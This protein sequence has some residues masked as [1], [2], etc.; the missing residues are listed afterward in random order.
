MKKYFPGFYSSDQEDLLA[1][2][3]NASIVIDTY[4]LLDLF[5][6][7]DSD[8]FLELLQKESIKKQLW[9]SYDAAWLYH[10]LMHNT[11]M[12]EINNVK[13]AMAHITNLSQGITNQYQ[14]PHIED[15]LFR[16]IKPVVQKL[17]TA[18]NENLANLTGKLQSKT[19]NIVSSINNLYPT[20]NLGKEFNEA[21]LKRIY[22]N[23]FE[24]YQQEIPPGYLND[25]TLKNERIKYHDLIIWN[26]IQKYAKDEKKNI[27]FVTNRIRPDWFFIYDNKVI[28]PRKE[29]INEFKKNT[30]QDICIITAHHFVDKN[31]RTGGQHG[32][33]KKLLEQLHDTPVNEYTSQ[34]TEKSAE[35]IGKETE[36]TIG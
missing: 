24:R 5:R 14:Y 8:T 20:E 26:E 25:S 12:Q 7:N 17:E 2:Q 1:F 9:L 33:Y 30:N 27:V 16:E 22:D 32:T 3:K 29:L 21:D 10:R 4:M 28:G 34:K 35:Q 23:A 11:L 13:S 31:S 15:K 6:I 19:N 36:N 18:L